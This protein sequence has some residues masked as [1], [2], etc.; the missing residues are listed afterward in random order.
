MLSLSFSL[1]ITLVGGI[2][3][4]CFLLSLLEL[5]I[6]SRVSDSHSGL[7]L[8]Q[9][10]NVVPVVSFNSFGKFTSKIEI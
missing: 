1:F 8:E 7:T 10:G 3:I 2:P 4:R 9:K 5:T 6:E